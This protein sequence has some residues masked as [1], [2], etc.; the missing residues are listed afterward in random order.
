[1]KTQLAGVAKPIL[2]AAWTLQV[3]HLEGK[4]PHTAP[5][6]TPTVQLLLL[7]VQG[8][9]LQLLTLKSKLFITR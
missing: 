4:V 1:M 6:Q 3:H 5:V 8:W 7:Y 9:S 2:G